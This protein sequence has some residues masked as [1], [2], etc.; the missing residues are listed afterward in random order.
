MR[1]S[2]RIYIVDDEKRMCDSLKFLLEREGFE[3]ET[4]TDCTQALEAMARKKIDLFILDICLPE[5][6]GFELLDRIF[7]QDPDVPIIMMTG[8]ASIDSAVKALKKGAYDYLRKPFEHE[9]LLKTIRNAL[10]Q[11]T[12]KDENRAIMERLA[13]S[14]KRYRYIVQHSPDIIYTLDSAGNFTFINE[15]VERLLGYSPDSLLGKHIYTIIHPDDLK[16]AKWLFEERRSGQRAEAGVELRLICRQDEKGFKHFLIKHLTLSSRQTGDH[17]FSDDTSQDATETYG[18]ARDVSYRRQLEA[19]FREAQKMEAIGTLAGGIAHDF[20]N[21]LTCIQ[22]YTSLILEDIGANHPHY[23]K[24]LNIEHN[25][26]LGAELTSRLLGFARSGKFNAKAINVNDLIK[27]SAYIF[28]R[29]KKEIT[30]HYNLQPDL[31]A[32]YADEGQ[33]EQVLLNLFV[34][35]WQAMPEGGDIYIETKNLRMEG[36]QLDEIGAKTGDY[37]KISITD[38]G[39]GMDEETQ[40]R[41]FEPFFT[42]KERGLGT[43]LGLASVYGIIKNHGGAIRVSSKVDEGSTFVIYLPMTKESVQKEKP[44]PRLIKKGSETVLLVDDEENVVEVGKAMLEHMGY[45]VL[46]ARNGYEAVDVYKKYA[47]QI[48]LLILDMIMP[49]MGGGRTFDIIKEINASIKVLLSSGY[50]LNGEAAEIL[51]RGCSGFI[52]KPFTLE[53]LS[54]KINSVLG[55][56]ITQCH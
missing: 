22:G 31:W 33:L 37:V 27:R 25:V 20:N 40:H 11:K 44:P 48:D 28:A 9:D 34:N 8:H 17:G 50:S 5:M 43:G 3:V 46:V 45:R 53:E 6:D 36:E 19:Q 18:V 4:S 41:V 15:A 12:L 35:A 23:E 7:K 51:R 52:Q 16:K 55:S 54:E 56:D 1:D 13:L 47:E 14:E 42:T 49:G 2:E 30:I 32:V 26:R 38:T 10:Q 39:I 24:L 21:L 29:T